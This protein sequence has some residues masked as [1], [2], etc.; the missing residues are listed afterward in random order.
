MPYMRYSKKVWDSVKSQNPSLKFVEIGKI[1]G[2]MWNSL[3]EAEKSEYVEEY[4]AE[5][6]DYDQKMAAYKNTPAYQVPTIY[7]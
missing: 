6:L 7:F 5:K 3:S 2:Q 1:V 4:E